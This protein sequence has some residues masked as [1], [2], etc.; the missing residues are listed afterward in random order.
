MT[1]FVRPF[2]FRRFAVCFPW[3]L[4][5]FAI[6][7]V[8]GQVVVRIAAELSCV[9]VHSVRLS[10]YVIS[11]KVVSAVPDQE[12]STRH[13]SGASAR[14]H[15]DAAM[16]SVASRRWRAPR[17]G[18]CARFV[19]ST[20]LRDVTLHSVRLNAIT[21]AVDR[22]HSMDGSCPCVVLY[23]RCPMIAA[24]PRPDEKSGVV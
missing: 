19:G 15:V 2:R 23:P 1:V 12:L 21:K 17:T 20:R 14:P 7:L 6:R 22:V 9:S 4:G 10:G 18:Y 24:V 16:R 5:Q 13:D 11:A 8:F 3:V